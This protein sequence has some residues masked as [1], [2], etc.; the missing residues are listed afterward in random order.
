MGKLN[1]WRPA[2][3]TIAGFAG[4]RTKFLPVLCYDYRSLLVQQKVPNLL[5]AS[6]FGK[7]LGELNLS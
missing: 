3:S 7:E 4:L 2:P 5:L 1:F 6:E